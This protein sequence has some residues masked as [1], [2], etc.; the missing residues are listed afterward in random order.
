MVLADMPTAAYSDGAEPEREVHGGFGEQCVQPTA[1]RQYTVYGE[2]ADFLEMAELHRP[3]ECRARAAPRTAVHSHGGPSGQ[4]QPVAQQ[5]EYRRDVVQPL[6]LE[7]HD[8]AERVGP[9]PSSH[10]AEPPPVRLPQ[11][12]PHHDDR[13]ARRQ[14]PQN[15]PLP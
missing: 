15:L 8:R 12:D 10:R 4:L 5:H 9:V 1:A 13:Q 7:R 14:C 6:T 2:V 3:G 11:R